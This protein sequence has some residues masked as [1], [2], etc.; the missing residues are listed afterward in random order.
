MAAYFRWEHSEAQDRLRLY[1]ASSE[2]LRIPFLKK[3]D[4]PVEFK[5]WTESAPENA[6]QGLGR[7]ESWLAQN[8][9]DVEFDRRTQSILLKNQKLADL[10]EEQALSLSAPPA[11]PLQLKIE[12]VGSTLSDDLSTWHN[13]VEDGQRRNGTYRGATIDFGDRVF[14]L[15][16]VV[17]KILKELKE[18]T[19]DSSVEEQTRALAAIKRSLSTY[20]GAVD[21]GD[22]LS[23]MSITFASAMSIQHRIENGEVDFDP[24]LFGREVVE[25]ENGDSRG[26]SEDS[27]VLSNHFASVFADQFRHYP[28]IKATYLLQSGEYLLLDHG[29]QKVLATV[30]HYQQQDNKTKMDF[31][32]NP[33][34]CLREAHE[35]DPSLSIEGGDEFDP[36][37]TG[38]IFVET[39]EYSE[40]VNGMGIWVTPDIPGLVTPPNNWRPE[41]YSF[42]VKS[43]SGDD[44]I[45]VI[46]DEEMEAVRDRL[47]NAIVN[48]DVNVVIGGVP[49]KVS[50]EL[51]RKIG[52]F[53][54]EKVEPDDSDDPPL[55]AHESSQR[56]GPFVLEGKTNL[57]TL[58]YAKT[59]SPRVLPQTAPLSQLLKKTSKL[60][61]HQ[62]RAFEWL[63]KAYQSGLPGV[64]LADDMGLGKTL[65]TL[66]FASYLRENNIL[67]GDVGKPIL[68][69]APTGLLRNWEAEEE[70]HFEAPG[71]GNL[72][73]AYGSNLKNIR[74]D[75]ALAND[76]K[77]GVA[78]LD[79][80]I[81]SKAD[82]VLTTYETLRDYE[83][84]FGAI[85][86]GLLIFDEIQK[87][88]NPKSRLGQATKKLNADFSI[89]LTGTPVENSL[90]D[91]WM[92]LDTLVPGFLGDL[93][94]FMEA[95][96]ED[97]EEK[98]A[99]LSEQLLPAGQTDFI[100]VMMRRMKN[101][102]LEGLP[103]RTMI[104]HEQLMPPLQEE[105]YSVV[106]K[107]VQNDA[108]QM[109]EALHQYR[110]LSLHPIDP[111]EWK[112]NCF[113]YIAES[114]RFIELFKVLDE[115][116]KKGEKTLIFLESR[117]IQD[118]LAQLLKRKYQLESQPNIINGEVPNIQRQ[119]FVDEFQAEPLGQ[120]SVMI[121]SPQAGGVGFTMTNANHVIHLSRW[122]NPAIEDQCNDRIYRIGQNKDVFVHTL[123]ARHSIFGD[124]SYDVQLNNILTRKRNTAKNVLAP[125][126]EIDPG[127]FGEVFNGD[128]INGQFTWDD[129]DRLN[130]LQ[131]ERWIAAKFKKAGFDV[132]KTQASSDYGVDLLI[133]KKN[134]SSVVA[135]I[136]AK[137]KLHVNDSLQLGHAYYEK[138]REQSAA[139]KAPQARFAVVSNARK[140]SVA[141]K[142]AAAKH[143]IDICLR[144]ELDELIG[145][146][147]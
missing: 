40:R 39:R 89:G 1:T 95:Y 94:T 113:E 24:V 17:Q 38:H 21:E 3:P 10:T 4:S 6:A 116:H 88:K 65:Q 98:L 105:A 87:A 22:F 13:W 33:G 15:P 132:K 106:V 137:H 11:I 102:E 110:K 68:I 64:L 127:D 82:W 122:W 131:F 84:S 12:S 93:K 75:R 59:F 61:P 37:C 124:S 92:I 51:H 121:V 66:A 114:A 130:P 31:I 14:R 146:L 55:G 54:P 46:P 115:I 125:M 49:V 80:E 52:D 143:Q 91:L 48:G 138:I 108:L 97:D 100:P 144:E 26:L 78:N 145:S 56:Q 20:G 29:L 141:Q 85:P 134:D 109:I 117:Q 50:E 104:D 133:R 96:P 28:S 8:D 44:V 73:R 83:I 7:I 142:A 103:K 41:A 72:I 119:R 99:E 126:G 62:D 36:N 81:I 63:I 57:D 27:A 5:E 86:F 42:L 147:S 123:T 74:K 107:S 45:V 47:E 79:G 32:S 71:I 139:Y 25:A 77:T 135:L 35:D 112:K 120:F 34:K 23:S 90:V 69:V 9:P 101:D 18:V 30:K 140:A 19:P 16:R 2:G 60:K 111:S 76:S 67:G 129:V 70:L 43:P 128:S 53:V 58:E 136:Q 118:F